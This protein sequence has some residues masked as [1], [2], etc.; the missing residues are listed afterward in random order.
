INQTEE[1]PGDNNQNL[2]KKVSDKFMVTANSLYTLYL[3]KSLEKEDYSIADEIDEYMRQP[4]ISLKK[5]P[6]T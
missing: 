3:L 5:D 1:K 4:E 6:L 2:G